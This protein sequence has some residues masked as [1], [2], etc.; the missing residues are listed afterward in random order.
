MK[1]KKSLMVEKVMVFIGTFLA[2][3]CLIN[4]IIPGIIVGVIIVALAI[5]LVYVKNK[6]DKNEEES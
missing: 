3:F 6:K 1:N 5:G 2:I 4:K